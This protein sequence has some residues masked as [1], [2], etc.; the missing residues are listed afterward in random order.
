M[1]AGTPNDVTRKIIEHLGGRTFLRKPYSHIT[2]REKVLRLD[3]EFEHDVCAIEFA[4]QKDGTYTVTSKMRTLGSTSG[5]GRYRNV[6]QQKKVPAAS[7][8]Q[9]LADMTGK[10]WWVK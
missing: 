8:K 6:A 3:G 7:L 9:T 5:F 2:Y 1:I 10:S 4:P